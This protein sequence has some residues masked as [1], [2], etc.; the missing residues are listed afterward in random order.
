MNSRQRRIR[1]RREW[2]CFLRHNEEAR[3]WKE[4]YSEIEDKEIGQIFKK[5]WFKGVKGMS[6]PNCV[7]IDDPYS[8]DDPYGHPKLIKMDPI[9][10]YPPGTKFTFGE[11]YYGVKIESVVPLIKLPEVD[12]E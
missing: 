5:E 9:S 1:N 6:T 8:I 4:Q 12:D 11:L 10:I 3:T 7:I 2:G